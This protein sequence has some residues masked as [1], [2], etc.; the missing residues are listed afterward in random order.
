M[1]KHKLII[2]ADNLAPQNIYIQKIW[3]NDKPLDRTWLKHAEIAEGGD[4]EV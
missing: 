2:Q 3:L 1:G 4:A